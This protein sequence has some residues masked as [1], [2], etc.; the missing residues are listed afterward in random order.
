MPKKTDGFDEIIS[1]ANLLES[2]FH[3]TDTS[4]AG[5]AEAELKALGGELKRWAKANAVKLTPYKADAPAGSGTGAVPMKK[6]AVVIYP[7]IDGKVNQ[8]V[9][10]GQDGRKCLYSCS[11]AAL[12]PG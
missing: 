4:V 8:C 12:S 3:S 10:V 6:C 11:P 1:K 2:R 7:V 9:L 5:K